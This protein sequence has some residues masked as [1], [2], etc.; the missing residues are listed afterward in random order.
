MAGSDAILREANAALR[1][2][3]IDAVGG[4]L[5][6]R[7]LPPGSVVSGLKRFRERESA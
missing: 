7:M 6:P 2:S 1:R 4:L 5:L 3:L